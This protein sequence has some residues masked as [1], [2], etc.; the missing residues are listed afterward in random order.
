[1]ADATARLALPFIAPG[2]AQ[3]ELFHNEALARIDALAQAAAVAIGVTDPPA[4]PMPGQCWVLGD[5]PSGAWAGQ[6]RA[7][8]AWTEGGWRFVAPVA[9]MSVWS[10][11]DGL[12]AR[13]DGERWRL[14][15]VPARRF[16]VGGVG[17]VGMQQSAIDAPNGGTIVDSEGRAVISAILIALRAHGLIDS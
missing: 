8:A 13:F 10:V 6:D 17:V 9:G 11:A 7:L 3:K 2:Q 14:G 4:A 16:I 12:L 1:M 5:G 15:D